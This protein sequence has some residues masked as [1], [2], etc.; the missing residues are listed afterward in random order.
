MKKLL[1]SLSVF[2]SLS[3]SA[4]TTIYS[5]NAEAD[6]NLM[7]F[8]NAD[9]DDFNWEV[10]DWGATT[11]TWNAYGFGITS[12]SY[13]NATSAV[14]TPDNWAVTPAIDLTGY[15]GASLDFGRISVDADWPSENYS[16]Y[17]VTATS[18]AAA[19]AAFTTATP[20]FNET[21]AVGGEWMTKTV[22][23]SAFDG[24]ANVYIAFRHH[25]S[26]D[27]F[28]L[29]IDDIVV[30]ANSGGVQ[31]VTITSTSM[32][33]MGG[34][35]TGAGT[36]PVNSQITLTATPATGYTFTNWTIGGTI[37]ST[38]NPF[39]FPAA[40]SGEVVANFTETV[41]SITDLSNKYQKVYPNPATDVLNIEL[42]EEIASV[43]ITTL[44]GKIIV[45]Q[46]VNATSTKVNVLNFENGIYNYKVITVKGDIIVNTFVK[47]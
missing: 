39:I 36:V 1:L 44:D 43:E 22:D 38:E 26:T 35:V 28:L 27:M 18:P 20:L 3:L 14:L 11:V 15:T 9:G 21:V 5:A 47:K 24:M 10:M 16:V 13:D 4:Q 8:V 37:V 2:A 19:V 42:K 6:F 40:L 45:S 31:N 25:A 17:A 30:T 46:E 41:S 7:Q 12:A 32:P 34:T 23:L 29:N 33:S